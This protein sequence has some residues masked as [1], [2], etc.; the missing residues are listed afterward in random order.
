MINQ[1]MIDILKSKYDS[2][3]DERWNYDDSTDPDVLIGASKTT[4]LEWTDTGY[5]SIIKNQ[6]QYSISFTDLIIG[7]TFRLAKNYDVFDWHCYQKIYLEGISTNR[8][9]VDVPLERTLVDFHD[10]VW[11]YSRVMRPGQGI[12]ETKF[13]PLS[14]EQYQEQFNLVI[15][16]YYY[17]LSAFIRTGLENNTNCIPSINIRNRYLDIT[18]TP[19]YLKLYDTWN[20]P[21]EK[22]IKLSIEMGEL[23]LTHTPGLPN[24]WHTDWVSKATEKWSSLIR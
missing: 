5:F 11:E 10:G 19:T 21:V 3:T 9:S 7:H 16:D 17:L 2:Y 6:H 4:A 8:F 12:G 14:V 20:N 1:E 23:A 13:T 22:T 15:D 18:R 24:T